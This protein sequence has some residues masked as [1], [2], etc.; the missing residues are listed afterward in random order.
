M[1][2]TV[3]GHPGQP[4]AGPEKALPIANI[5][6]ANLGLTFENDGLSGKIVLERTSD[7]LR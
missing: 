7:K 3:Y 1:E 5:T 2:S 6:S 4:K